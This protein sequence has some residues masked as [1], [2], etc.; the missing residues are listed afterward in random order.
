M[1]KF[2]IGWY[3]NAMNILMRTDDLE[4]YVDKDDTSLLMKKSCLDIINNKENTVRSL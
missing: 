2:I 4:K 3:N 1:A